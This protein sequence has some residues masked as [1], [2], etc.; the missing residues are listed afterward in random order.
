MV[1][2]DKGLSIPLNA[3]LTGS[4][5]ETV[6]L[7]HGFGADQTMW[8][9]ILPVLSQHFRVL[10]FDWGFSGAVKEQEGLFDPVKHSSYEGFACDLISLLDELDLKSTVFVGHSM[11]GM[12]GCIASVKRPDL[13][14]RLILLGASP[15]YLNTDGYEGGFGTAQI[16]QILLSI[17]SDY[18]EWAPNFASLVVHPHDA[19]SVEMFTGCLR[20]MRPKVALSL[21]RTVFLSDHREVLGS[22]TTPCTIIQTTND[23]IVPNSVAH[24]MRDKIQG[25][26]TVEM[27]EADGHFPQLTAHLQL[28]DVLG[29]I[30]GFEY[31]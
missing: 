7:A 15:R 2:L 26:S 20:R 17:E 5:T 6:V 4:G 8:D 1:M 30:L 11:S 9:K 31:D 12:I 23:V 10:V 18:N 3:K 22:V 25:K 28:L 29:G 13:F 16:D 14:E 19:L 27:I 24:Y 21:A